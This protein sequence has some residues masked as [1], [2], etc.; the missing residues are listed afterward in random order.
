MPAS[1]PFRPTK[2]IY[3]LFYA[4]LRM[5]Q[6]PVAIPNPKPTTACIDCGRQ[7]PH[8]RRCLECADFMGFGEA[9]EV[10]PPPLGLID[11][12]QPEPSEHNRM[13]IVHAFLQGLVIGAR[14]IDGELYH[15][16]INVPMERYKSVLCGALL[17]PEVGR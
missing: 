7:T 4:P 8:G 2:I 13:V 10:W 9:P 14:M 17:G 3:R 15:P 11:A 1:S 12:L 6:T 5:T 16:T